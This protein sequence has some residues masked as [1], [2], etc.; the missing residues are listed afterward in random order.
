MPDINDTDSGSND[1]LERVS[2]KPNRGNTIINSIFTFV[3]ACRKLRMMNTATGI[4]L[5]TTVMMYF[6]I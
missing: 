2:H 6:Y 1:D 5:N 3:R 4:E